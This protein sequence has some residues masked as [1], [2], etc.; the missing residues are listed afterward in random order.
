LIRGGDDGIAL[1]G[2]NN[3]VGLHGGF[4]KIICIGGG[5]HGIIPD[6]FYIYF[7]FSMKIFYFLEAKMLTIN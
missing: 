7:Q 1:P 3:C 4:V 6:F 5:R 2:K